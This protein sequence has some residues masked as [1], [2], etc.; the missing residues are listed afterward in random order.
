MIALPCAAVWQILSD[1]PAAA[2]YLLGADVIEYS[3]HSVKGCAQIKFGPMA[4]AFSRAATIERNDGE[5][6]G[7]VRGAGVDSPQRPVLA[8]NLFIGW[9]A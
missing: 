9:S 5:M 4:A 6:T 1:I 3:D 2:A 7:T 8:A